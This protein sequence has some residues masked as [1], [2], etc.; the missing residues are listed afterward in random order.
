PEG[1]RTVEA[2][3]LD[4]GSRLDIGFLVLLCII[5]FAIPVLGGIPLWLGIVLVAFFVAYLWRAGR[6]GVG[7]DAELLGA[8][9][10][11]ADPPRTARRFTVVVLFAVSAG[12]ILAGA[13]PFSEALVASGS[14]LGIDSYFLVQWL[15]P[16]ASEA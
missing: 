14:A 5:A 4:P 10:L 3:R 15:A 12:I 13:E 2:L 6:R 1:S 9:A 7:D 11:I 8:A 16:A